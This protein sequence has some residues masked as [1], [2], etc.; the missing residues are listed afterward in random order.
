MFSG[1]FRGVLLL[2]ALVVDRHMPTS[3]QP[4]RE[5]AAALLV[6]AGG[7]CLRSAAFLAAPAA[8]VTHRASIFSRQWELLPGVLFALP[9]YG[10]RRGRHQSAQFGNALFV[11]ALLNAA[12]HA[13][14]LFSRELFDGPFFAAELLKTLSY[15]VMFFGALLDQARLF[16]QVRRMAVSDSLTGLANYRRLIAVMEA[17]LDRSRRTGRSFSVDRKSTRL[18]SSDVR[19]SY[20]VFCLQKKNS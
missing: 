14:A 8:P 16:E 20:A 4:S 13:A 12:C 5:L 18:S 15:A 10:Y 3:R 9:A 2:A 17:E 19:I 1:T 7:G 11:V 6:G